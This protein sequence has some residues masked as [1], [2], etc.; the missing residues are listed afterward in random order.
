MSGFGSK[1]GE[2]AASRAKKKNPVMVEMYLFFASIAQ[3][4]LTYVSQA[5]VKSEVESSIFTRSQSGE[6]LFIYLS[7]IQ[8]R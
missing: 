3:K 8:F 2:N 1:F 6:Y 4:D 5:S 7:N